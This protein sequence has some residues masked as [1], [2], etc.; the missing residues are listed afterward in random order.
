MSKA[1]LAVSSPQALA[2]SDELLAQIAEVKVDGFENVTAEDLSLT[3]LQILQDGSPQC[4][5]KDE[6]YLPHAEPGQFHNSINNATYDTLAVVPVGYTKSYVEWVDRNKGGGFVGKYSADHPVVLNAQKVGYDLITEN[7]NKLVETAEHF[8]LCLPEGEAPFVAIFPLKST[9]LKHSKRWLTDMV[10]RTITL[11]DGTVK[12][13]PSFF[14]KYL[15]STRLESNNSGAWYSLMGIEFQGLVDGA[16][17]QQ[18]KSIAESFGEVASKAATAYEKAA[19]IGHTNVQ[20][21][22]AAS[23]E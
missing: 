10:S 22:V 1:E 17:A 15:L 6:K 7:G 5:K 12:R 13:V 16:I 3:Y 21:A 11:P 23:M 8:V 14:Q 18:A 2:V 9:Q 20:D 19:P 4:K